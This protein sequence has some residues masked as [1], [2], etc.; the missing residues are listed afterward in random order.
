M[1]QDNDISRL[2]GRYMDGLTTNAEEQ[3]L[4]RH[5][6]EA[7]V[8]GA[9]LLPLKALAAY[10]DA[11]RAEAGG[12]RARDTRRALR[13]RLIRV[14]SAAA[15]VAVVAMAALSFS[16]RKQGYDVIDGRVTTNRTV[17]EHEAESALRMMSSADG[18]PF[19]AL[20]GMR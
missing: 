9:D 18:D 20:E 13:R 3:T 10:V 11:E 19:S 8:T 16:G 7:D 15:C 6:R 1:R 2:A 17:V 12:S 14:A 4:R 5:L